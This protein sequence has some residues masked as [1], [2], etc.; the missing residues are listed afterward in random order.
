MVVALGILLIGS[1][2]FMLIGISY[3]CSIVLPDWGLIV[4][5]SLAL[6]SGFAMINLQTRLE[7]FFIRRHLKHNPESGWGVVVV[8]RNNAKK[9]RR[10]AGLDV[11]P[12][13]DRT[14]TA[15]TVYAAK[16]ASLKTTLQHKVAILRGGETQPAQR[17]TLF[18][19]E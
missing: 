9:K 15:L 12:E 10:D 5:L 4:F 1:H 16:L 7:A 14:G 6:L 2:F 18:P 19:A 3:L 8:G 11:T 17:V 13:R